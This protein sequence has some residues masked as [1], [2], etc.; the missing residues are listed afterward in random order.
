MPLG[1]KVARW[2]A[3]LLL[4]AAWVG[5]AHGAPSHPPTRLV[6]MTWADYIDPEVVSEFEAREG[7]EVRFSYYDSDDART[8]WLAETDGR[9]IDLMIA[10]GASLQGYA[11]RGWLAPIDA[12]AI[13]NLAHVEARWRRAFDAAW[14]HGVPY[15]W[16]TLG[17]AYRRDLYPRGLGG[18]RELF[19]PPAALSGRILMLASGRDLF[20]MALKA[21]GR[22][23]NESDPVALSAAAE[24]LRSQRPHVRQYGYLSISEHSALITGE[25]WVSMIFS[26]DALTLQAIEPEIVYVEPEEGGNLWIDYFTVLA[27]SP[28]QALAHRFIDFVNEP[29]NAARIASFVNYA[30]P[31]RAAAQRLP[32]HFLDDPVIYPPPDVLDRAEVYRRLPA[33]A[34]RLVNSVTAELTAANPIGRLQ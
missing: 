17:I 26:G 1:G 8:E 27:S 32:A 10:S 23:A 31:N 3:P 19:E 33:R 15:F 5:L 2:L 4:L 29:V 30:T 7:V 28:R 14:R 16:G 20:A 24:L 13:P 21:L 11:Q 18:W 25:A 34:L 22:S 9:G 6:I 12:T